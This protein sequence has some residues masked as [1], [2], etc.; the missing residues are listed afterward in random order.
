MTG[1]ERHLR[2]VGDVPRRDDV[3]PR[4]GVGDTVDEGRLLLVLEVE[5]AG[6]AVEAADGEALRTRAVDEALAG[7]GCL[8]FLRGGLLPN[9]YGPTPYESRY[10][11][12]DAAL[13]FALAAMRF[14]DHSGDDAGRRAAEA[15]AE[16][17]RTAGGG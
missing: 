1:R 10:N 12:C 3:A 5:P 2:D 17:R 11:S 8:P 15:A 6:D 4:V 14:A 16:R 13:W 7:T 9:V